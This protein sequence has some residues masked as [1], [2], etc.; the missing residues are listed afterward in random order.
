MQ[1]SNGAAFALVDCTF[2]L[3][4][5]RCPFAVSIVSG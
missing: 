3:V 5:F 2:F 1:V 4:W